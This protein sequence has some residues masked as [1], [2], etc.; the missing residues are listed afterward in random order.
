MKQQ[1]CKIEDELPPLHEWEAKRLID[2]HKIHSCYT[3][4]YMII[5]WSNL[6]IECMTLYE[7]SKIKALIRLCLLPAMFSPPPHTHT[8]SGSLALHG[9]L[10]LTCSLLFSS[11]QHTYTQ[12]ITPVNLKLKLKCSTLLRPPLRRTF[13]LR[14]TLIYE[15]QYLS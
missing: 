4:L 7:H 11:S 9:G 8:H 1:W 5:P 10:A 6:R 14:R 12:I 2:L 13:F 15:L 3:F